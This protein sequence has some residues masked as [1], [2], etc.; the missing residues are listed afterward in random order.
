M[1]KKKY[2]TT[3]TIAP[4]HNTHRDSWGE[5]EGRGMMP[6]YSVTVTILTSW[7]SWYEWSP[8]RMFHVLLSSL[9]PPLLLRF[10]YPP[11]LSLL[12]SLC[13]YSFDSFYPCILIHA[14]FFSPP[15]AYFSFHSLPPPNPSLPFSFISTLFLSHLSSI[16]FHI[17]LSFAYSSH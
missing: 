1:K 3:S 9:L 13:L 7:V 10:V 8:R 4:H 6:S 16:F 14:S 15:I 2:L 12:C 11:F 5:G 17:R